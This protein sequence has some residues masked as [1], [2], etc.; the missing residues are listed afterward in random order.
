MRRICLLIVPV[1]LF[2]C[3]GEEASTDSNTV[4]EVESDT[5]SQEV[6]DEGDV[7]EAV[8][9]SD[10][11]N[12]DYYTAEAMLDGPDEWFYV[13][14]PRNG[15]SLPEFEVLH[16][17]PYN[18]DENDVGMRLWM[19]KIMEEDF[20]LYGPYNEHTGLVRVFYDESKEHEMVSFQTIEGKVDGR[21]D[22]LTPDGSSMI[23][24]NYSD[25]KWMSSDLE[26]ASVNWSFRQESSELMIN[27]PQFGI[28]EQ[29]DGSRT[30]NLLQSKL[31]DHHGDNNLYRII[32]KASFQNPFKVNGKVM[33]GTI[34]AFLSPKHPILD[35]YY[36]L[37]FTDGY[38]DGEIMIYNSWGELEL[39]E[40]FEMGELTETIF[41][42]EYGDGVA[43][44]IIYLYPEKEQAI[45][46]ELDFD[47]RLTHTYPAYPEDGWKV[48]AKPDGT[49]FD[50]KGKEYYALYWEG[51]ERESF[52]VEEGFVVPGKKSAEFLETSLEILGLNRREANEFIVYWLPK[53]ENNPYN[54]IHFSSTQYEEMAALTVTPQPETVIRVMMVYQ[55]LQEP[56]DIPQQNLF[57][58]RKERK[59]FTLVEW[60]GTKIEDFEGGAERT[61]Q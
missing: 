16:I 25:G 37:P 29:E 40:R 8:G 36:I 35:T 32:Q 19:M 38:L 59:G 12:E 27:D 20:K 53:L 7:E 4:E 49:L 22:L 41:Q 43:K 46:V 3:G 58:L 6:L 39:H 24:R 51:Q 15:E 17:V 45:S 61:V 28:K 10:W 54:L 60:G 23:E 34:Q 9:V 26:M 18:Y 5:S 21:V 11:G 42:L 56:M 50:E 1:L 47:G 30:V 44:P 14:E 57:D 48:W 55:P 2:S 31:I 13:V 33:N 52:Q